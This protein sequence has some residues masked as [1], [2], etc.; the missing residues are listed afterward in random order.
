MSSPVLGSVS[1]KYGRILWYI[2]VYCG[3]I[4]YLIVAGLG[5]AVG[6]RWTPRPVIV[7]VRASKDYRV[8]IYSLSLLLWFWVPHFTVPRF[9]RVPVISLHSGEARHAGS[10][11]D[12]CLSRHRLGPCRDHQRRGRGWQV[13]KSDVRGPPQMSY[14]LNS[15]KGV[16]KRTII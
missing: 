3:I 2:M 14:C 11:C 10:R 9:L 5:C 7:T 12:K 13:M 6:L 8:L 1:Y 16:R 15:S 4:K